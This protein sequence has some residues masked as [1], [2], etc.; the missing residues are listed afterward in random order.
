MAARDPAPP[1]SSA[2]SASTRRQTR[3]TGRFVR[4]TPGSQSLERGLL[5]LRAFRPGAT[6]LTNAELAERTGLPRPTVS[7]L[8]RSLVDADFLVHDIERRGYRLGLVV[9]SLAN[10]F[11]YDVPV[12]EA[13]AEPMKRM[14]EGERINVGLAAAD[15][16]EMVYLESVRESRRGVFRTAA[17]GSR[18]PIELTAGGRS[19]LA[20]MDREAREELLARLA[21]RHGPDWRALRQRIDRARLDVGRDGYCVASWQP[22]L[23]VVAAPLRG[24]DQMLYALSIGFHAAEHQQAQLVARH[25]PMLL[26][27]VAEIGARW[28]ARAR[29]MPPA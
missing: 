24:P 7:R 16:L 8:T 19:Y 28:T 29:A 18:F 11:R 20:G 6:L 22:G 14:A 26:R 17:R 21:P 5:I 10:V 1:T 25:A 15:Q 27:L 3:E 9:T 2:P 4:A 13:A 23:T 12:L